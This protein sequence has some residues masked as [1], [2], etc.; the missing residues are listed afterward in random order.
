MKKSQSKKIFE[1]FIFLSLILFINFHKNII[2][3]IKKDGMKSLSI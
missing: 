1:R 2:Y 3:M